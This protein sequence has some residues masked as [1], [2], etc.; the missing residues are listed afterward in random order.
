MHYSLGFHPL[1]S[2]GYR[3]FINWHH[4]VWRF[5]WHWVN[6]NTYWRTIKY[7]C[8]RGYRGYA[9]CDH[10]DMDS[11]L[12]SVML[13]MIHDLKKYKHGYP[14]NLSVEKW[15]SILQEIIDGLE[16]SQELRDKDTV[17]EGTFS[18]EPI[19]WIPSPD[20]EGCFQMKETET[21]RFNKELYDAWAAPLNKKAFRA[22]IL[23]ARH[24]QSLWD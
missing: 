23:L 15:D 9:S 5:W 13:G 10:W 16:A 7:F 17:P 6:P 14:G 19:E 1:R 22:K 18:K 21:P 11:Y 3:A 4:P 2:S 8:Q 20:H 24:W 12:E